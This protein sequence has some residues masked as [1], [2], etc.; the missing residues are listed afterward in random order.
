MATATASGKSLVYT[1]PTLERVLAAPDAA[2]VLWLFPTKALAQD[3]LRALREFVD[4]EAAGVRSAVR[5]ATLDGDADAGARA[6]ARHR[7]NVLL[8]NPD[9]LH[10]AVLPHHSAWARVLRGLQ[11]VVLDECHTY[12]GIF[13]AHVAA[14]LRRL[15]RVSRAYGAA[16]QFVC[17]SATIANPVEH[18]RA[19]LPGVAGDAYEPPAAAPSGAAGAAASP[20]PLCLIRA[21]TAAVGRRK[22]I[23]W[24]PPLLADLTRRRADAGAHMS[25]DADAYAALAKAAG[26]PSSASTESDEG[27]GDEEGNDEGVPSGVHRRR[28]RPHVA[29]AAPGAK[30]ARSGEAAAP[31]PAL[32]RVHMGA[33][34]AVAAVDAAVS[35]EAAEEAFVGADGAAAA[36]AL[37]PSGADASLAGVMV[38]PD[39]A[40]RARWR[41]VRDRLAP[42][43]KS[44]LV[45]AAHVVAALVQGGFKT[46]CFARMRKVAEL[47]LQYT[48]ERLAAVAPDAIPRVRSYRAGYLKAHRRALEA[49][50][51]A[52]RLSA[53]VATNA[54]ELGVD[55]GALDAVVL[56]GYPGS[57]ASLWQQLGRA[58]RGGRDG[59]GIIVAYDSPLEQY[60]VRHAA[61]ML[62]RPAEPVAVDVTNAA[63][64]RPHAVCAAFELPLTAQD[65]QLFG[66]ALGPVVADLRGLGALVRVPSVASALDP[67]RGHAAAA[68]AAPAAPSGYLP[69]DVS[70]ARGVVAVAPMPPA[71]RGSA[72]QAPVPS[73]APPPDRVPVAWRPAAWLS[74]PATRVSLRTVDPVV[75]DVVDT[76]GVLLDQI[77]ETKAIFEVHEGAVYMN[78]GATYRVERLDRATQRATV[79]LCHEPYFTEP[80]DFQDM[81]VLSRAAS[82]LGG[83][84]HFGRVTIT[85]VVYGYRKILKR[86]RGILEE[87]DLQM[88]PVTFPTFALWSDVTL[89]AR[90]A[91]DAAGLDVLGGCHAAAHAVFAVLPLFVPCEASDLDMECCSPDTLRARPMRFSVYDKQPGGV[92][93][94]AAAFR[95]V[96]GLFR[97]ALQLLEDCACAD[98]CPSCAQSPRCHAFNVVLDKRAAVAL[99]RAALAGAA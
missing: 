27:D 24:N 87:C 51:F 37:A 84:T 69:L 55:I 39:D 83:T 61:A 6:A 77:E 97:A 41:A 95:V 49:E 76:H 73:P 25:A 64:L 21:A 22:V 65:L 23:T 15:Q 9:I 94:A 16:P 31:A 45:E 20:P 58:G 7:A 33:A 98:G 50:M 74:E 59:V 17:A 57:A 56:L 68:A 79:R 28:P 72:D 10:A 96:D 90:A 82:A 67:A 34:A 48:H 93:V 78:S 70:D 36:V 92:G 85:N 91:L 5:E 40:W 53:I 63:V 30:R 52:G 80:R 66:R 8:A 89:A 88:P 43:R 42:S 86:G 29:P 62:A 3:Q 12:R 19:L 38:T 60:F 44:G 75:F 46:L 11:L 4:G 35:A 18:F 2:V 14:V 47:V 54:L 99:L 71:V 1:V 26:G 13:G 32:A 81:T